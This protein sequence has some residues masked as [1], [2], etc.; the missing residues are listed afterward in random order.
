MTTGRSDR[1]TALL[2]P[3]LLIPLFLAACISTRGV[4]PAPPVPSAEDSA[5]AAGL[6]SSGATAMPGETWWT[7]YNDPELDSWIER[8]LAGSPSLKAAAARVASAR[9]LANA[10]RAP[11]LPQVGATAD[12]TAERFSRNGI[13]PPPLGGNS[14]TLNDALLDA[15][16]DP[17]FF[18]KIAANADAARLNAEALEIDRRAAR[19]E[20]AESIA[21]TWF[22]IARAQ[23]AREIAILTRTQRGDI[24]K[25]VGQ[26][27]SAGIDTRVELKQAEGAVPQIAVQVEQV[28]EQIALLRHQ[29]ATLA[30]QPPQSA[31]QVDAKL[32]PAPLLAIP[33]QLPLELLSRRADIAAALLRVRAAGRAADAA[34]A[35]FYPNINITAFVGFNALGLSNVFETSSKTWGIEPAIHLPLFDAGRIRANQA[36][37]NY[38][39]AAAVEAYNGAVL[40]AAHETADA[41]SS[42]AALDRERSQQTLASDAAESAYDLAVVRYRAGLGTYL[43]VLTADSNVLTQRQI[44]SD[45]DARVAD[46]DVA[47]VRALGGGWNA[48]QNPSN[49]HAPS[50]AATSSRAINPESS[51]VQ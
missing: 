46:L 40:G 16:W 34:H 4:P 23:R 1:A 19:A 3:A 43:T 44:A 26:R 36:S 6:S 20:L 13:F 7:G 18:G 31:D 24:A 27:V 29:L 28:D 22:G 38:D 14:Y 32:P 17:D 8:G 21:R 49:D 45:L 39:V 42:I 47:L 35:D 41:L 37:K 11:L 2:A 48:D 5:R 10:A 25:L 12:S 30:A 9:A 15:N 51:Y 50:A 33:T